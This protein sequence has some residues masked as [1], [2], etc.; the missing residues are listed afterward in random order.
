[1]TTKQRIIA[2]AIREADLHE[3]DPSVERAEAEAMLDISDVLP[4]FI[5]VAVARWPVAA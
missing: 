3:Y 4:A 5:G 1:M 2:S